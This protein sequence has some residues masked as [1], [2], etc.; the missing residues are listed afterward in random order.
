M[1]AVYILFYCCMFCQI[2]ITLY[3]LIRG[4][5]DRNFITIVTVSEGVKKCRRIQY[6]E[7]TPSRRFSSVY[8][9]IFIHVHISF[10]VICLICTWDIKSFYVIYFDIFLPA[11]SENI[12]KI[13][14]WFW[15]GVNRVDSIQN[16]SL[17][18]GIYE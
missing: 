7:S 11:N 4:F 1:Y 2:D 18:K 3:A 12:I 17:S 16:L 15:K 6:I 14:Y 5:L 9:C 13:K 10:S 8:I